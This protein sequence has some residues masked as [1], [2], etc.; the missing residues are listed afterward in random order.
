MGSFGLGAWL[1]PEDAL[2]SMTAKSF[3]PL[4]FWSIRPACGLKTPVALRVFLLSSLSFYTSH[5]FSK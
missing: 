5:A 2:Q 1:W 4:F 3:L